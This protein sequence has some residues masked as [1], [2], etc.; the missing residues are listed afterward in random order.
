MRVISEGLGGYVQWVPD[1]RLV[2]VRYV[3][4]IPSTPPPAPAPAPATPVPTAVPTAPPTPTPK[5]AAKTEFFVAGDAMFNPVVYN[6]F[7]PGNKGGVSGAGRAGITT[8]FDDISFLI[9]GDIRQFRYPHRGNPLFD[10]NP[11]SPNFSG[12]GICGGAA[13]GDQGCVS[14]LGPASGQAFVNSFDA[15]DTTEDGRV[16]IGIANPKIYLVGSYLQRYTNYGYPRLS[17]VGAGL[18]KASNFEQ[19]IDI[20][21]SVLYYPQISGNYTDV[22]GNSQQLQY[23]LL[24]YQAGITLEVP[25]FPLFLDFGYLGDHGTEK[26]NAPGNF[27]ENSLYGGLGLHF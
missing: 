8:S 16:G 22:F 1:K 13:F 27:S 5:K 23:R 24:H 7:D 17:G 19:P 15:R 21:G 18:E 11:G 25:H 6:E 2:V 20:Y 10:G 26:S 9:E 4:S 14:V 12:S 3:A